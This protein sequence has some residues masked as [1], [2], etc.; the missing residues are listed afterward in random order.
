MK[1]NTKWSLIIH[2]DYRPFFFNIL[3]YN[4]S[5]LSKWAAMV[6][7]NC[8]EIGSNFLLMRKIVNIVKK[9]TNVQNC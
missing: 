4:P 2:L 5:G 7:K 8:E 1:K 6:S 9:L 3:N